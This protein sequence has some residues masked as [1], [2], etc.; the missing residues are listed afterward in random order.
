MIGPSSP[1]GTGSTRMPSAANRAYST[2]QP[3]SSTSTASPA[4]SSVRVTT[5]SAWVAP[6]VVMICCGA[7]VTPN[8]ASLCDSAWRSRASPAG[9]P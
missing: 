8:S 4:R 2:A 3:G 7:A 1:R 5:S 6:T 9:S